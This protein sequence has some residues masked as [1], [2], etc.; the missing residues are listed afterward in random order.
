M[1]SLP[2]ALLVDL[3]DT[4][5]SAYAKPGEAWLHVAGEFQ[6]EIAPL[7]P[8]EMAREIEGVGIAFWKTAGAE[9][10]V[11]LAEARRLI[12]SRAFDELER[13]RGIRFPEELGR[14]L[15]DRFTVYRNEQ[16][17]VLPQAREALDELRARGVLL[18]LVTNGDSLTQRGK[19]E[20]FEL[21]GHFDHVQIEGE[22][23]FGKPEE[24]AYLHAMAALGVGPADTWMVG[25]SLEWEVAGP[26]RLGIKGIWLDTEGKGLPA[27]SA[28]IPDRIVR[29]LYEFLEEK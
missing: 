2:R 14:R 10:R 27:D 9:H 17:R 28:V 1:P 18:A 24:K 21:A 11:R 25:D 20:R 12:V 8:A 6:A 16:M 7:S 5:I 4:L 13:S 3:D 19:L 22:H 23:G 26:K 29:T 15:A